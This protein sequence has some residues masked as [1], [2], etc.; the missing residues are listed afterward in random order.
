MR[1]ARHR[2]RALRLHASVI[3]I[4]RVL[5]GQRVDDDRFGFS[6]SVTGDTALIGA[7]RS[8]DGGTNAGSA[9]V[10]DLDVDGLLNPFEQANGFDPLGTDESAGDPD[11]DGLTNLAEQAA[12]TDPNDADTDGFTDGAEVAAASDP[13]A[14]GSTPPAPV[15]SAPVLGRSVLG[16][17]MA[18]LGWWTLAAGSRPRDP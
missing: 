11:L 1:E 6:V 14:P 3:Q 17:L 18:F 10:V 13:L 8:D 7:S 2:G 9:Y 4:P 16:G 15:P 12:R 5:E